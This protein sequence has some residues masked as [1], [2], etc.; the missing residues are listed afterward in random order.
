M[1]DYNVTLKRID[2]IV[3]EGKIKF[4]YT[5]LLKLVPINIVIFKKK[6]KNKN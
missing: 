5:K 4:Y 6:T 3:K 2:G 1:C